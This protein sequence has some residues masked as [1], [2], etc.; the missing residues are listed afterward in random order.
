MDAAGLNVRYRT[1]SGSDRIIF[2]QQPGYV[3]DFLGKRSASQEMEHI[4]WKMKND[5]VATARGSVTERFSPR[6]PSRL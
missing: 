6:C 2:S 4:K 5:P 1:A 3:N